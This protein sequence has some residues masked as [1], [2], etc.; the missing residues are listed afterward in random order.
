MNR[1]NLS[2]L[3]P[4][5]LL[6]LISISTFYSIDQLL[7]RQQL[8]FFI[9]SIVIYLLFLNI[10]YRIFGLYSRYV[11]IVILFLFIVIFLLG[12]EARG[13]VR[14]LEIFGLR[15][16]FSEIGK[17]FLIIFFAEFL[18][19]NESKSLSKFVK[20]FLLLI[21]F[22]LLALKQP[23]L[24]NA[25]IYF[26]VLVLMLFSYGFPI[27]YFVSLGIVLALPVPIFFQILH[28]YQKQR[29]LS[30]FNIFSDPL[31]SSYN[32][33]QSIISVGSGGLTG[34]GLGQ[35]TQSV[36]QFLPERHTDFI[37]ATIAESL[38]LIGGLIILL[39]Y[40]F[41]L[42]RMLEISRDLN[43]EFSKLI[44]SGFFSLFLIHIF[45]NIGMN[46]GI[47]P[48]VGITLPFLSYGGSSLLTNFI[49]LGIISSI[50]FESKVKH[51]IE[52]R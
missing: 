43:D 3:L 45:F 26:V 1:V 52:I 22:F 10:D 29:I 49:L 15:L 20:A 28:E 27:R 50:S 6:V 9:I 4:S 34:K 36:L 11:Y 13:A 51:S 48:I 24:G 42:Y 25:M 12:A 16:Q 32:A 7:F 18:S 2:I 39:L 38:G 41:L 5:M 31:G 30:F 37:F 14:W 8:I 35:A 23:D 21:P 19:K 40:F 17:P 33:I 44:M 47:F 46:I